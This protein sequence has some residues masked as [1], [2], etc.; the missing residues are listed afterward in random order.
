MN[1][2]KQALIITAYQN[3]RMLENNLRLFSKYF[4]CY[5][6]IYKKSELSNGEYLSRLNQ[7]QGVYAISKYKINWG[8]YLHMMAIIDLLKMAY[9]NIAIQRFHII[10]GEDFPIKSYNEFVSFFEEENSDKNYIELTNI[11]DMPVVKLRYE[12]YHFLHIVNR[13]SKNLLIQFID[14]VIRQ[15]QYHLPFKR[16][17]RFDYKGLIWGSITR[18]A[19]K[20]VFD[21]LTSEMLKSL[22]YCEISEEFVLQNSLMESKLAKTVVGNN[23][24]YANWE[25]NITGP[26]VLTIN[27]LD[28]IRNSDAFFARKIQQ[29]E[30]NFLINELYLELRRNWVNQES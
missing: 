12:K 13:K 8:S 20:G 4:Y 27:E 28:S 23:M 19:V 18:E 15:I 22:K 30:D 7:I 1:I 6:H 11:T 9:K 2:K 5:V 21:Y 3:G 10:S 14:K 25:G 16:N 26:K 29:N 17:I 24:R